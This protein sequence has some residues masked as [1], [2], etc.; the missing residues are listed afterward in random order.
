VLKSGY[1]LLI[2][3]E[4]DSEEVI[5]L[6]GDFKAGHEYTI[7]VSGQKDNIKIEVK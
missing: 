1:N 4:D 5:T 6:G 2:T 7:N 3:L